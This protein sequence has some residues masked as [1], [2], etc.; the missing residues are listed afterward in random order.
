MALRVLYP[1]SSNGL[2]VV[3]KDSDCLVAGR[4]LNILLGD[5]CTVH[6]GVTSSDGHI[7]RKHDT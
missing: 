5:K 3:Y 2:G 6:Y 4:G 1:K 7:V